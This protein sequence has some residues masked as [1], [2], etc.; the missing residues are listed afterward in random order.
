MQPSTV[1]LLDI[2]AKDSRHGKWTAERNETI[3]QRWCRITKVVSVW[4]RRSIAL[5]PDLDRGMEE[6]ECEEEGEVNVYL[7]ALKGQRV[8]AR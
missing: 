5:D 7:E 4:F 8:R 3:C 2:I 6:R 1:L